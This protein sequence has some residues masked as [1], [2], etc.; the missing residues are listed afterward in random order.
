MP[1]DK[2]LIVE[3]S[4]DVREGLTIALQSVGYVVEGVGDGRKALRAFYE[5]QPA[6]VMLDLGLPGLS[7]LEVCQRLR[8]MSNA[9]IIVLSGM[10]GEPKKIEALEA[11][12][13]DYVVKGAGWGELIARVQANIRRA[14]D[15][16]AVHVQDSYR[17]A[18]LAVDF[19]ARTVELDER[20]VELTPIEYQ[21]LCT[22][23]KSKGQPVP[24]EKLLHSVWGRTYETENLV[25]WHMSRLRKKLYGDSEGMIVTRRGFGYVYVE[26][27]AA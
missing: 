23:I 25:K 13:D 22:L 15:Q 8:A 1:G 26:G 27:K 9:P 2:I 3:D 20:Q 10:D 12:A 4:T 14:R 18:R 19:A 16:D 6:L 7:G 17:D 5:Y 24:A 21:L 11:G